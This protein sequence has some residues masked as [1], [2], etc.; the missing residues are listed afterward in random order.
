MPE[1]G[2]ASIRG[3]VIT[4]SLSDPSV[5]TNPCYELIER[6]PFRL[7]GK[8]PVEIVM[9]NIASS[10]ALEALRMLAQALHHTGFYAHFVDGDTMYVVFPATVVLVRKGSAFDEAACLEVARS[11]NVPAHQLPFARMF[12]FGHSERKD[13]GQ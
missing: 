3:M 5:L 7:D 9:V 11:W 10:A 2:T 4:E 8:I 12:T 13:T 1:N 6:Y